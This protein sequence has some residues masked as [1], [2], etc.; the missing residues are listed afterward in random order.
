[1]SNELMFGTNTL[2]PGI[3][4]KLTLWVRIADALLAIPIAR[5]VLKSAIEIA[6]AHIGPK[7]KVAW[8]IIILKSYDF[9][10]IF[11]R[12]S[13][14]PTTFTPYVCRKFDMGCTLKSEGEQRCPTST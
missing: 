11:Q 10:L 4:V 1:M 7:P 5:I 13:F 12:S 6:N 3:I 14:S 8:V 9:R 2:C